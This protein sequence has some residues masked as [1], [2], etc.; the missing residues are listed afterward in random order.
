MGVTTGTIIV[1]INSS[2]SSR[3]QCQSA[4]R[5]KN[6]TS[7]LGTINSQH[8]DL[9][10]LSLPAADK[11]PLLLPPAHAWPRLL[12]CTSPRLLLLPPPSPPCKLLLLVVTGLMLVTLPDGSSKTLPPT[13]SGCWLS[14]V[15]QMTAALHCF[16]AASTLLQQTTANRTNT[17]ATNHQP[18]TRRL[19]Q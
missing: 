2:T 18:Q 17:A 5:T 8:T 11:L 16:K 13:L 14:C 15:T 6:I 4:L 10:A 3:Q 19:W 1:I 9:A 12:P 7:Q